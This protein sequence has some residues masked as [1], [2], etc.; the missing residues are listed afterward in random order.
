MP[1]EDDVLQLLQQQIDSLKEARQQQLQLNAEKAVHEAS[2]RNAAIKC[3]QGLVKLDIGGVRYTTSLSTLTAV[4]DSFFTSIFSGDWQ[5]A[6]TADG[7]VFVD[8]DGEVR[9]ALVDIAAE[10]LLSVPGFVGCR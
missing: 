3:A 5:Q 10:H 4:P 9:A 6:Q 8:R 1:S 2:V 7:A